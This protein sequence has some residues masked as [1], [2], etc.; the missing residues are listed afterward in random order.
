MVTAG[1]RND[2]F[3]PTALVPLESHWRRICRSR[4]PIHM[5]TRSCIHNRCDGQRPFPVPKNKGEE[6]ATPGQPVAHKA[7]IRS[8][9]AGSPSRNRRLPL[10][11]PQSFSRYR[12]THVFAC[13]TLRE[14]P[15]HG[16]G[17]TPAS[18]AEAVDAVTSLW[19]LVEN[20]GK[21]ARIVPGESTCS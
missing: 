9:P 20:R 4:L 14:V 7:R 2:R 10:A 15:Q 18:C 19:N 3:G 1:R 5:I 12:N 16:N 8:P 21:M 13:A 6:A 11:Q 17:K